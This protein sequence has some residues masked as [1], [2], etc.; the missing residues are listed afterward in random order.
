MKDYCYGI[1]NWIV[2]DKYEIFFKLNY[3]DFKLITDLYFGLTHIKLLDQALRY[4]KENILKASEKNSKNLLEVAVYPSGETLGFYNVCPFDLGDISGIDSN[5]EARNKL[6]DYVDGFSDNV[7]DV[8]NE[9]EFKKALDFL[10]EY[11]LLTTLI[12]MVYKYQLDDDNF[13]D[14][15]SFMDLF[16]E[17]IYYMANDECFNLGLN[18]AN[19]SPK[20]SFRHIRESIDE[21]G[22]FLNKL[23]LI[24][25]NLTDNDAF[26]IYDPNSNG[27]YILHKT[28]RDI[29]KVN[30]D[31][32]INLFG[33]SIKDEAKAI[34]LAKKSVSKLDPYLISD[35][36]ILDSEDDLF[37]KTDINS[38]DDLDFIITNSID[39]E[40]K[41]YEEILESYSN[42]QIKSAK[43][44]LAFRSIEDILKTIRN[45]I[46]NDNLEAFIRLS[47][48]YILIL[49]P[50]KSENKKGCFLF[51][52]KSDVAEEKRLIGR[53][54]QSDLYSNY[55]FELINNPSALSLIELDKMIMEAIIG[56]CQK[57]EDGDYSIIIRN[58]DLNLDTMELLLI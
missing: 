10:I 6:L 49:N 33:K 20:N 40:L 41:G 27:A 5:T 34:Y 52:D 45:I 3:P 56:M 35:A 38:Y 16:E 50:A 23:I 22:E 29:S 53:T 58:D 11:D 24:D 32:Q 13:A 36:I 26:N 14:Y 4:S 28:K 7:K 47:T 25:C 8:F 57:Y 21:Y 54:R 43:S 51:I 19:Y 44:V 37:E 30:P 42:N 55:Q 31:A 12:K 9:I 39:S 1:S 15:D 2:I 17:F 48:H 46:E 18:I